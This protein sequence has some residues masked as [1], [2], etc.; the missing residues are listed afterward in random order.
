MRICSRL[1]FSPYSWVSECDSRLTLSKCTADGTSPRLILWLNFK[2]WKISHSALRFTCQIVWLKTFQFES[3]LPFTVNVQSFCYFW[4]NNENNQEL[5]KTC[6][7]NW[8][9]SFFVSFIYIVQRL[10][11]TFRK[12]HTLKLLGHTY[13]IEHW[14]DLCHRL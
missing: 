9:N 6:S 8:N 11:D 2:F 13:Y 5:S 4:I 3:N 12:K 1:T 10:H 7:E 14:A